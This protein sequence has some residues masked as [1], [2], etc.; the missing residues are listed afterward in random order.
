MT[1]ENATGLKHRPYLSIREEWVDQSFSI[2]ANRVVRLGANL[3]AGG[4][5]ANG[6][7]ERAYAPEGP[8]D[9]L[10]QLD[11]D[12]SHHLVRVRRVGIGKQLEAFDGQGHAWRCELADDHKNGAL[13]RVLEEITGNH[14]PGDALKIVIA[15][16]VPKGDRF[17]WIVEKAT[18]LGVESLVPLHCDRSV[19]DP[20]EGKLERLRKSVIEA[21]KQC[22]RN[23]LMTIEQKQTLA[24]F[25]DSAGPGDVKLFTDIG[26][27]TLSQVMVSSDTHTPGR[28]LVCVGPEGGWSEGERAMAREKGWRPVSLGPH[29]LRIETA[30]IAAAAAVQA[31]DFPQY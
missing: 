30:V 12:E 22:R 6:E 7:M 28:V 3:P 5:R 31:L 29:V 14:H 13:L 8:V 20:R 17:D 26:G 23:D 2:S 18:E 16:A 4:D 19:V 9:G 24:E 25:L 11:R 1:T 15:T 21:C 27:R 10:I